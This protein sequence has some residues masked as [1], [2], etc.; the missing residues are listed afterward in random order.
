MPLNFSEVDEHRIA[1]F[2]ALFGPRS[3]LV[4][5]N[6]PPKWAWSRSRDVFTFWQMNVNISKTVQNRDILTMED[7]YNGRLIG[8]R[9][10]PIKWQQRCWSWMTFK[11]IHRLH[12]F[13]I[14]I[15]RTFMQFFTRI[16]LTVCSR[17]LYVS[18]TSRMNWEDTDKRI[19]YARN[20]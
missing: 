16:Q 9:I 3:S 4:R 8:Y 13:S 20:T 6:C 12:A 1:K 11:V 10:W 7:T 14:A 15:R 5:T 18:W 2:S 17:C 19:V